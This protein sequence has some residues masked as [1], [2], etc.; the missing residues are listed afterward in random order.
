MCRDLL[1]EARTLCFRIWA[2]LLA[3]VSFAVDDRSTAINGVSVKTSQ[4][5]AQGPTTA[6]DTSAW[7]TWWH[8]EARWPH[9]PALIPACSTAKN[10]R[11]G[12]FLFFLP[13]E[14]YTLVGTTDVKT[15]PDL[16]HQVPEDGSGWKDVIHVS[17]TEEPT[18]IN[19][20]DPEIH[21]HL[22]VLSSHGEDSWATDMPSHWVWQESLELSNFA[23]RRMRSSTWST[24]ARSTC[25]PVS[26]WD[27]EAWQNQ[28]SD[29]EEPN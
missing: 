8:P 4:K 16:H 6:L 17:Y 23:L 28:T 11:R 22:M 27:A 24:N 20:I 5:F 7:L 21:I 10:P 2:A 25:R 18:W 9:H 15:K 13:W 14:G 29:R 12:S 26:A 3:A 1:T 19:H